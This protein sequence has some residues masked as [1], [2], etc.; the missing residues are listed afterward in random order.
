MKTYVA[1]FFFIA[2]IGIN[3]PSFAQENIQL[4]FPM[5]CE[6]GKT[7]WL[8]NHVD[9][10]TRKGEIR[11]AN[12]LARSYDG[13]KGTDIA[14]RNWNSNTQGVAILSPAPGKVL[15]VRNGE[16]DQ[17]PDKAQLDAIRKRGRGC[18][19][20]VRI[21]HGGGW[22]T[23]FCHMKKGSVSV[24]YGEEVET[25]TKL[26]DVGMS[27]LTEH[28]HMHMSLTRNGKVI[29]PYTGRQA[30]DRCGLEGAKNLWADTQTYDGFALYDT[31]FTTGRPDFKAIARG[32]APSKVHKKSEALVFY[33][34]YFGARLG[35]EIKLT[36]TEP[37]GTL[38]SEQNIA[39]ERNR[40]RQYYF[41]GHRNSKGTF[42]TGKW[43]AT[44]S[45]LRPETGEHETVTRT[46]N[47]GK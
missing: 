30:S 5:D 41:T 8:M 4:S 35:D 32:Q 39:Q 44:A 15:R 10:D 16:T 7:C 34:T 27:G 45:I 42:M 25:G 43:T 17:F 6:L 3:P 2:F 19:N 46:V 22:I 21:D 37:D 24:S 13:H 18:G 47:I 31:G 11:D 23:Q 38:F 36:I 20:G 29:D 9:H 14:I 12:C 28:P 33:M 40:A 26:G 1:P